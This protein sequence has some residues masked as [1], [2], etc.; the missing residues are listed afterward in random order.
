MLGVGKSPQEGGG[1][2]RH[3][4]CGQG[5]QRRASRHVGVGK[6]PSLARTV[7]N[8]RLAAGPWDSGSRGGSLCGRRPLRPHR[9]HAW[10]VGRSGLASVAARSGHV[11]PQPRGGEPGSPCGDS[12]AR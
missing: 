9:S 6:A 5:P 2:G 10:A 1:S 3:V 4:V 12:G 7:T 11:T 8:P